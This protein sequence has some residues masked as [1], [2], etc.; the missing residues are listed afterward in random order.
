M[1]FNVVRSAVAR[2]ANSPASLFFASLVIS[3]FVLYHKIGETDLYRPITDGFFPAWLWRIDPFVLDFPILFLMVARQRVMHFV[4]VLLCFMQVIHPQSFG[5]QNHVIMF[6]LLCWWSVRDVDHSIGMGRAVISFIFFAAAL[7]KM[8]PGWMDGSHPAAYLPHIQQKLPAQ[9]LFMLLGEVFIA[10]SFLLPVLLGTVLTIAICLGMFYCIGFWI[11]DGIGPV[12]TLMLMFIAVHVRPRNKLTIYF[13]A[14]C[15]L[16]MKVARAI[17]L[18][19]VPSLVQGSLYSA[20]V[21]VM[22]KAN[23]HIA[24]TDENGNSFYGYDTYCEMVRRIGGIGFLYPVMRMA[25]VRRVGERV[26]EHIATRRS[27]P[28]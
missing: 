22:H 24:S 2:V 15:G 8:T 25:P 17:D 5:I 1:Y 6:W 26:Y 14:D 18:L 19:K 11:F 7:G 20:P 4:A 10:I 12:I 3:K 28:I 27:C 9:H 21:D 23:T 16:C 13:D